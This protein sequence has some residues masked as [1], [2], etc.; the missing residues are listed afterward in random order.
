MLR[1]PYLTLATPQ[2]VVHSY[3]IRRMRLALFVIKPR[4]THKSRDTTCG[5]FSLSGLVLDALEYPLAARANSSLMGQELPALVFL[6]VA[7]DM[8]GEDERGAECRQ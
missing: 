6:L 5:S 3:R 2:H 4:L 1:L 8:C 7:F